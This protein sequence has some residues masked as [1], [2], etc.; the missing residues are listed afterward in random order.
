VRRQAERLADERGEQ[1]Q[2]RDPEDVLEAETDRSQEPG[3]LVDPDLDAAAGRRDRVG[4]RGR[5]GARAGRDRLRSHNF[6]PR[7]RRRTIA[8]IFA[9]GTRACR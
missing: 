1:Q 3:A 2:A 6:R 4:R 9:G 7:S 5:G 8:A